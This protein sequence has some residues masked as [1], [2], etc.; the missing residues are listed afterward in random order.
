MCALFQ[1]VAAQDDDTTDDTTTD[2]EKWTDNLLDQII[3]TIVWVA[4]G[5]VLILVF[6]GLIDVVTDRMKHNWLNLEEVAGNPTAMAIIAAGLMIAI[7]IIIHGAV[8]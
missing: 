1:G 6:V 4:I 2:G 7:A 8:I 3:S 5:L